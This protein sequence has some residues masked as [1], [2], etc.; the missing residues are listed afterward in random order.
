MSNKQPE[1]EAQDSLSWEEAVHKY[2]EDHPDFFHHHPELLARL[3]VPHGEAGRAVS[4]IE[5]QVQV[6]RDKNRALSGQLHQLVLIAR[7]NDTLSRRLHRFAVAMIDSRTLDGVLDTARDLL[8]TEF[9]LEVVAILLRIPVPSAAGRPEFARLG[10]ER[11][12]RRVDRLFA[13]DHN[14]PVCGSGDPPEGLQAIFDAA[15][16]GIS[17]WA[18]VPLPGHPSLGVVALGSADGARFSAEMG[19]VYLQQLSALFSAS[20]ARYLN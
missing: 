18:V 11:L 13:E 4:L 12:W 8:S 5:R 17:S 6:L 1:Q 3:S 19:T 15:A 9:G 7:E 16:G 14:R 10:D 20:L 2:L